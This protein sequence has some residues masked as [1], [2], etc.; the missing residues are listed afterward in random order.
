ME[1]CVDKV[2][3]NNREMVRIKEPG[4]ERNNGRPVTSILMTVDEAKAL[5]VQLMNLLVL[6]EYV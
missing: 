5:S 6:N 1:N 4:T 3:V 2:Q